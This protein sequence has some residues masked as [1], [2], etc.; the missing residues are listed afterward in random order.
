[1]LEEYDAIG[2][3]EAHNEQEDEAADS[4]P[5]PVNVLEPSPL[6][7][8]QEILPGKPRSRRDGES[9]HDID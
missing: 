3:F 2:P 8:M 7:E 5:D 9:V 6:N 1:M 4:V